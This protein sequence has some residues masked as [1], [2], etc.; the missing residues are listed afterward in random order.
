[1]TRDAWIVGASVGDRFLMQATT[2][3]TIAAF[4]YNLETLRQ[5]RKAMNWFDFVPLAVAVL[6]AVQGFRFMLVAGVMTLLVSQ[7]DRLSASPAAVARVVGLALIAYVLLTLGM[8][9][10]A[11]A[12]AHGISLLDALRKID[13][14]YL[15]Y[16][17]G[18]PEQT[19]MVAL[20]FFTETELPAL[21]GQTYVDAVLRMLPHAL[22]TSFF[23]TVR[24]QDFVLAHFA[25]VS[26]WF[27]EN[28]LNVGAHLFLEAII[29]FGP[30]G[31]LWVALIAG[32]AVPWVDT[33]PAH[34]GRFVPVLYGVASFA[35]AAAWYGSSAFL[36]YTA[37]YVAV[38]LCL[39]AL[40]RL[41]LA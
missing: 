28:Q 35:Y 39:R 20:K 32:F 16:F 30:R 36:K 24:A 18:A 1:M 12:G 2:I 34:R 14:T 13:T 4:G 33:M 41:R 38:F 5:S 31:G 40:S 21:Y 22:H 8:G 11:V 25:W 6:L 17:I 26:D 27:R 9:V 23:E 19:G 3:A 7:R 37:Y 15:S 29:N 10:R